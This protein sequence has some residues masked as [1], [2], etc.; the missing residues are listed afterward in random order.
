MRG[1]RQ[2]EGDER[3]QKSLCKEGD[4]RMQRDKMMQREWTCQ[5]FWIFGF[6]VSNHIIIH[7]GLKYYIFAT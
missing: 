7:F 5:Y 3:T 2:D 4:K 1:G 6:E